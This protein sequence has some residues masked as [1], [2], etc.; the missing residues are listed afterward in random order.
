MTDDELDLFKW[1]EIQ[2]AK[3]ADK[4]I[5]V[6]VSLDIQSAEYFLATLKSKEF[7]LGIILKGQLKNYTFQIDFK[8]GGI[9]GLNTI[10]TDDNF[11]AVKLAK[12]QQLTH[13]TTGYRDDQRK[14]QLLSPYHSLENLIHLN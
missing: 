3:Q 9:I 12:N 11:P 13:V 4:N 7:N 10:Y 6:L 2:F 14:L 1:T 8:E 5:L